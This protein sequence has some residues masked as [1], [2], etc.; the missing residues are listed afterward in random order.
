MSEHISFPVDAVYTWVNGADPV[1][2]E[3]KRAALRSMGNADIHE[4]A[5]SD[6]RFLDNDELR[7]SL[8]SL[9]KYAPWVRRVY[10]VTDN[11]I[12]EWLDDTTV[13][14][15][16]H[17]EIF[18]SEA[19]YPVFSSR[20]IELCLHRIPSLAE[21]FLCFNDDFMLGQ[22]VKK[23]DFF[24]YDGKPKLWIVSKKAKEDGFPSLF[25][26]M[27]PHA[28]ARVR[29]S[30]LVY[31]CFGLLY[32]HRLAHYPKSMTRSTVYR[33]W[34]TFS[35][36]IT[37]TLQSPFRSFED[38]TI[39]TLYPY[40]MLATKQGVARPINGLWQAWDVLRGR[41]AHL[42]ASLGDDNF[43]FKCKM[44]EKLHPMTFCLNDSEKATDRE[45][46]QMIA[47]YQ[48]LFPQP[49]HFEKT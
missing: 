15:V 49:S 47:C 10:L 14:L 26:E 12:P 34:Q 3:R 29:A 31:N 38:I 5:V 43:L 32:E 30:Q 21:H 19:A 33:L 28:A 2:R 22:S 40:Y 6:C 36:S 48:K 23:E 13:T 17:K 42:G 46:Q 4:N 9:E 41:L 8:R 7:Y 11:Q 16:Q 25:E 24:Q 18:P 39:T 44:I 27:S 37:R 20:P 45:R 35:E 1:W